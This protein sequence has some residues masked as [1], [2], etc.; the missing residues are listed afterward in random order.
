MQ[1]ITV[2][3]SAAV[4]VAVASV[5]SGLQIGLLAIPVGILYFFVARYCLNLMK[6]TTKEDDLYKKGAEQIAMLGMMIFLPLIFTLGLT[7]AL[8][9]LVVFAQ[10]ALN[11]QTFAKRQYYLGLMLSF[12]LIMFSA[13][14]SRDSSFILYFIPYSLFLCG[15][16]FSLSVSHFNV[17]LSLWLKSSVLLLVCTF[18]VYLIMPRFPALLFGATPGSDHYYHDKVWLEKANNHIQDDLSDTP[19]DYQS[20]AKNSLQNV[21][22]EIAQQDPVN[23]ELQQALEQLKQSLNDI[24]NQ[25]NNHKESTRDE[26]NTDN[27]YG[28]RADNESGEDTA[29]DDNFGIDNSARQ[30]PGIIMHVRSDVP[31]YLTTQ[32]FDHFDG[33]SWSQ[34]K[35]IKSYIEENKGQFVSGLSNTFPSNTAITVGYEV[36]VAIDLPSA[37]PMAW[38][39]INLNFPASVLTQDAFGSFQAPDQLKQGTAYRAVMKNNWHQER[40]VYPVKEDNLSVYLQLPNNFDD[41]IANLAQEVTTK[42]IGPWEKAHQLEQ[43]LRSNYAY[44][45]DTVVSS[46]GKTPLSEFLFETRYGHC[47]F[48]A[49]AMAI[50]LRTLGIPSRVVNGYAATDQNPLTGFIEVRGTDGHAWTEAYHEGFGWVPYEPTAYYQ[51]PQEKTEQELTYEKV[52]EY[53][54]RQLEILEQ[55]KTD[56]S[57]GKIALQLWQS[58]VLVISMAALGIKWLLLEY[59]LYLVSVV[60]VL[61]ILWMAYQQIRPSWLIYQLKRKVAN[62]KLKGNLQDFAFYIHAIQTSLRLQNKAYEFSTAADFTFLLDSLNLQGVSPAQIKLFLSQ[63][64]QAAYSDNHSEIFEEKHITWLAEVF[65]LLWQADKE[66]V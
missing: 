58:V 35:P 27:G 16:L 33:I 42:G 40:L 18:V 15:A 8:L 37:I 24:D 38:Q 60:V 19:S 30:N 53:V 10:L 39:P 2:P 62:Y 57:A 65:I 49:S 12:A 7:A 46:Q 28:N 41:E 20:L 5:M 13:S 17:R 26:D 6:G 9:V 44:S 14:Q 45:L 48:F 25:A 66:T 32:I 21:A 29:L 64:N 59:G 3:Y 50:M 54:D 61:A 34:A 22:Q 47:E 36:E 4:S 11:L 23:S 55:Q 43:H 1:Q 31:L 56:W 63:F 51:L 52:N